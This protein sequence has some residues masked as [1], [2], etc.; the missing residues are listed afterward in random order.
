MLTESAYSDYGIVHQRDSSSASSSSSIYS[1]D[2][3]VKSYHSRL[4]KSRSFNDVNKLEASYHS[5]DA[6]VN[7]KE[8][9]R[10]RAELLK[11]NSMIAK[12]ITEK[13]RLAAS[14]LFKLLNLISLVSFV[15]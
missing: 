7:F 8:E 2:K 10:R 6:K 14:K 3:D 11:L 15:H 13:S 4:R 1:S 9:K 12:E 5:T